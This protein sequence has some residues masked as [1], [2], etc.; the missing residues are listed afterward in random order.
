LLASRAVRRAAATSRWRDILTARM[1][2]FT[3]E[4]VNGIFAPAVGDT[5][6]TIFLTAE[7]RLRSAQ[8]RRR[9]Y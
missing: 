6:E 7:R 2:A 8:T 4:K 9:S 3:F 5:R 1:T